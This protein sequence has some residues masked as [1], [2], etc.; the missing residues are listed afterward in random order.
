M[1]HP[2]R[3]I[4]STIAADRERITRAAVVRPGRSRRWDRL[5]GQQLAGRGNIVRWRSFHRTPLAQS[6]FPL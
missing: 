3:L 6:P 5:S 1:H 4:H 2:V